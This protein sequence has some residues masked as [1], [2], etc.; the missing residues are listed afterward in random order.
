MNKMSNQFKLLMKK[1]TF[2]FF[3]NRELENQF[4]TTIRNLKVAI[5]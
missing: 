1:G 3:N 2:E 5:E 4:D